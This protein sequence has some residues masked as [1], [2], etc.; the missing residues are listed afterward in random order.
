[1]IVASGGAG[2]GDFIMQASV[3]EGGAGHVAS[4]D[5]AKKNSGTGT[6]YIC[7]LCYISSP[8]IILPQSVLRLFHHVPV[9]HRWG[10]LDKYTFGVLV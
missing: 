10:R 2:A 3:T 4:D 8:S 1:M 5:H 9:V 7:A 6:F